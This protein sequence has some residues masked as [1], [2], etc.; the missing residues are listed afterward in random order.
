MREYTALAL[1]AGG[2]E[3][4]VSNELKKIFP[5]ARDAAGGVSPAGGLV[6]LESGF[7]RVRFKTDLAGLYRALMSLRTADRLLLEAGNFPAPDFDA[8]FEGTARI[9]WEDLIPPGM[10]LTV[11][12]ARSNRSQLRA[13]TS[14]QG[15]VH[16]AAA[17]RLCR[18]R[19]INR[20]PE[21]GGS[22]PGGDPR[23]GAGTAELRVY[24][25]KDRAQVL[26]DL[27]G[28]PL[29]K[30]GYRR[31]GGTAPLRETAAAAILLLAGWK[32]KFPLYDPLCGSGTIVA[33]AALYAWDFA[34]GLGRGF[35]L[36]AL[37]LGDRRLEEEIRGELGARVD[38]GR[39]LRIYGSDAGGEAAA[40]AEANLRR[41]AALAGRKGGRPRN[42]GGTA[43]AEERLPPGVEIR[44]LS[45]N[46]AGPPSGWPPGGGPP[47]E[48]GGA[49]EG[50]GDRPGGYIITN[51][52]YGRRLGD[53]EEAETRYRE[54]AVLG[55]A[56]PGWKLGVIC[57][58]PGFESHF[59][60]KAGLCRE[61]KNGAVDAYFYLY[62]RL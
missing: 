62:D 29:F 11:S 60:K 31:E 35:A 19:G 24:L 14:L 47:G 1:C 10:G 28:E 7:G 5:S 56:F 55:G 6:I 43:G 23:R 12:K 4:V 17:D 44:R 2:A 61:L 54:M 39:P 59:G 42:P 27:S 22:A 40:L 8:L 52:P 37:A 57:D 53:R 13:E 41:A 50:P 49:A 46:E 16:K 21:P 48:D 20:L 25:E 33:E 32:R 15:V 3:K 30:R 36:S 34:P 26:L 9:P 38:L 45:L 18:R 58:H 51:P